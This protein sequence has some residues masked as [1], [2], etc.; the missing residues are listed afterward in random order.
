VPAT[1]SE[2][3]ERR[4]V[5]E[6]GAL[7][8]PLVQ[9]EFEGRYEAMLSH[10]PKNYALLTYE[11]KLI[12]RGVAFRSSRAEPFGDAFLR[13]AIR[14]LMKGEIAEIRDVYVATI[15]SLRRRELTSFDVSSRVRLTKTP[16]QYLRTRATRREFPYEAMLT[17]GRHEWGA[18]DRVRVYR[19]RTGGAVVPE[20]DEEVTNSGRDPRDYDAEHYVCVL[21]D[22]FASRLMRGLAPDDFEAVFADPMQ[23]SL[24]APDLA[25]MS[26]VLRERPALTRE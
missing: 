6:V 17:S 21:R 8:P 26:P 4:V 11:G 19:A 25:S 9:L 15:D 7:L 12:L 10:E 2:D 23:P 20:F 24:F 14:H 13:R 16:E 18:G 3:D 22:A 5:S 1:W